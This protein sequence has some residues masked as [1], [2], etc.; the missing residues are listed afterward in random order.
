M[1]WTCSHGIGHGN[2]I[3]GCDGC[4]ER[5]D[6]PGRIK[7][8]KDDK[9]E[10]DVAWSNDSETGARVGGNGITSIRPYEELGKMAAVTWLAVFKGDVIVKRLNTA[11]V[12]EIT[13]FQEQE[14]NDHPRKT[15]RD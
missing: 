8:I 15:D 11:Y 6:Y 2:H 5:T 14:K 10:I 3:H 13:Y 7:R 4:C 1:E 9:R 12:G